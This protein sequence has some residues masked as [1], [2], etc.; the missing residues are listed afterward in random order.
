M[1]KNTHFQ[2]LAD[3]GRREDFLLQSHSGETLVSVLLALSPRKMTTIVT[4]TTDLIRSVVLI[5]PFI[6][7]RMLRFD[8]RIIAL[9]QLVAYTFPL[10]V[11]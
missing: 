2:F 6:T 3:L 5:D 4:S 11:C 1:L 8:V 10:P 7:N 9:L